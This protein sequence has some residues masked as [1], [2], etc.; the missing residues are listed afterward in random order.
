MPWWITKRKT[1]MAKQ[2]VEGAKPK[3]THNTLT[4]AQRTHLQRHLES[5]PRAEIESRTI[6]EL[7]THLTEVMRLAFKTAFCPPGAPPVTVTASNL[8]GPLQTVGVSPKRRRVPR[9]VAPADMTT[10]QKLDMLLLAVNALADIVS[11]LVA[12]HAS[13]LAAV[14]RLAVRMGVGETPREPAP[15]TDGSRADFV[16]E[17]EEYAEHAATPRRSPQAPKPVPQQ[18]ATGWS[19]VGAPPQ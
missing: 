14:E 8:K 18:P 2:P 16:T 12:S 7:A 1:N 5:M 15:L 11:H 19:A 10:D 9:V 17:D 6:E 4:G 13:V 3:R